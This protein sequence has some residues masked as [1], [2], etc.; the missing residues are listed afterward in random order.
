MLYIKKEHIPKIWPLLAET[1]L[2]KYKI[3]TVA[4][5]YANVQ[6]CRITPNLYTTTAELDKF[7][8][9]LNELS[10]SSKS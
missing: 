5:D 7:V 1:L 8:F 3:W 2:K 10:A 9:A 4:I 6:G